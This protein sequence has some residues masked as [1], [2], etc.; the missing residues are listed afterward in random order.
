MAKRT[1]IQKIRDAYNEFRGIR[2]SAKDVRELFQ[3]DDALHARCEN[4]DKEYR[5]KK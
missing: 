4:E 1:A 3:F 2:L 5:D